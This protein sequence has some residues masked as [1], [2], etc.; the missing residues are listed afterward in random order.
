MNKFALKGRVSS[1]LMSGAVAAIL[2]VGAGASAAVSPAPAMPGPSILYAPPAVSPQLENTGIWKAAPILISGVTAYRD[3]EFL[4]QDFLY[5]DRGAGGRASY[6][7]DPRYAGNAADFVELRVKP[8]ADATAIRI[9]YNS[10]L[11]PS[12]VAATLAFGDAVQK[13]VPP[14]GAKG[15]MPATLFVTVHGDQ[16]VLTD[17]AT[18]RTLPGGSAAVDL[19]RR[20][21]EVRVPFGAFDPRGKTV[22]VAAA[23]GLWD[24]AAGEYLTPHETAGRGG[25]GGGA[26]GSA[27]QVAPAAP[28]SSPSTF[29]NLAFRM[30]EPAIATGQSTA[31]WRDEQQAAALTAGDLSPFFA[32][33]DFAKLAAGVTDNSQVPTQGFMDRILVSHFET[34][35]GRGRAGSLGEGCADPCV[36]EYAGRLEPYSIYIPAKASPSAGYAL[37]F[38]LHPA[39][40]NYN[41]WLGNMRTAELGERGNGSIVVT[42]EGRGASTWYYGEAGAEVFEIWADVAR[43][44]KLDLDEVSLAGVSMGGFGSWKL[45]SQYPDLFA[46]MA[47]DVP[48]PSAGTGYDGANAPGGESSFILPMTPSF[49]HLPTMMWTGE[50]DTTCS[51][52]GPKG[53]MAIARSYEDQGFR[54][55]WFNFLQ[56]PHDSAR[57]F[58]TWKPVADFLANQKRMID[59]PHVSFVVNA[60]MNEPKVGLEVGHA[61]WV[62][63]VTLR[64][65]GAQPLGL[66]D[67]FS[68][69]QGRGDPVA[70]PTVKGQAVYTPDPAL[71]WPNY[72]FERVDWGAAPSTRMEDVLDVKTRNVSAL[73]I[74][75]GR[76]KVSC[77]AKINVDSDGPLAV[78]L[79][80]C[81]R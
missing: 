59:P 28:A 35:Q 66:V 22:R 14:F 19:L 79:L 4:Y 12:L 61:Y 69:G 51:V 80:G 26:P 44:Y 57:R 49:R 76:A 2:S 30:K 56:M 15:V 33:V 54:V 7:S 70:N 32:M 37:T 36:P 78:T 68:H 47:I 16:V 77:R 17:A 67:V 23:T 6:P 81:P 73:T 75:P 72:T 52:E 62:S 55:T 34:A 71:P 3:G 48:C 9:T 24:V 63:N 29:F 60:T 25:P 8:L 40:G 65:D 46:A 11:D 50:M 1:R 43:R 53:Q 41:R 38:D 20:Q 31:N 74:D 58:T 18:G 5:D 10:M 39:G 42:P 64:N 45:A 27:Q 21:V 13:A